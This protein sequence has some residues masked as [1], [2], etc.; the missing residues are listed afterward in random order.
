[1][2]MT[3][4]PRKPAPGPDSVSL[5]F[6]EAT[7]ERRLVIQ[8]CVD[9]GFAQ[10]PPDLLCRRCQCTSPPFVQASGRGTI[11]SF[12][13]YTRSFSPAFPAPY[14]LA[15]VTLDDHPEVRMMTNIVEAAFDDIAIGDRVRVTFERRG[16]WG[17]PQFRPFTE[18]A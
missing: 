4:S 10:F 7:K 15:L 17:L 12:A 14:A 6:W 11:Y 1:M 16:Q 9:C 5:P 3:A 8:V 18:D 2:V 13:V